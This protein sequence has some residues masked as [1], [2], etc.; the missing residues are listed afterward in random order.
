MV[1]FS[2]S[3]YEQILLHI[4]ENMAPEAVEAVSNAEMIYTHVFLNR[5][6]SFEQ[7]KN[8]NN[9]YQNNISPVIWLTVTTKAN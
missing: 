1:I 6:T 5:V 3:N 9:K 8:N 4:L 2:C 7:L